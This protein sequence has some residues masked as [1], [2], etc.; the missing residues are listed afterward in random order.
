MSVVG[1]R[2]LILAD[3][4]RLGWDSRYYIRRWQMRKG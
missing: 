2:P 4:Q 3:V 1:P